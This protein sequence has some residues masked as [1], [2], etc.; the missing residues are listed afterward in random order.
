MSVGRVYI[1]PVIMCVGTLVL[2]K[3]ID[4]YNLPVLI[5]GIL[6]YAVIFMVVQYSVALNEY[7]RGLVMEPIKKMFHWK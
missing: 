4:F 7:E 3:Y 1:I 2:A 6:V 5:A